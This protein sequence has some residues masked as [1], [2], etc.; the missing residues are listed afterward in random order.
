MARGA[1][2]SRHRRVIDA[3]LAQFLKNQQDRIRNAMERDTDRFEDV[4][5][6]VDTSRGPVVRTDEMLVEIRR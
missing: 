1:L 3:S 2:L 6:T 5:D 4:L